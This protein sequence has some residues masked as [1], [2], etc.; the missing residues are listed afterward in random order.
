MLKSLAIVILSLALA[1]PVGAQ[2]AP[3]DPAAS[4]S[5]QPKLKD[6]NRTI[7]EKQEE[8]GSR[9][10]GKKVCHTAAEWQHLR[11]QNREQV[12]DWQQRL[13]ANPKPQ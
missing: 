2:T 9:L 4:S 11:Q 1:V 10:G 3:A 5:S 13:T 7:C 12:D 6:P 8:V